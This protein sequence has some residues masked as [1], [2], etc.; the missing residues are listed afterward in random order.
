MQFS[1]KLKITLWTIPSALSSSSGGTLQAVAYYE[2]PGI[3]MIVQSEEDEA[4]K[5]A[6][7]SRR[8]KILTSQKCR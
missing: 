3:L 8:R 6:R 1:H 5:M 4:S 2:N 7:G